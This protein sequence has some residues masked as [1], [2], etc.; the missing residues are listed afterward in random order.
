MSEH[1]KLTT[2]KIIS[3]LDLPEDLFLGLPNISLLGNHEVYISNHRGILSYGEKEMIIFIKDYQIQIKGQ[4]L[5][6]TFY[7]K[8]ELSIQ[9]HILSLEFI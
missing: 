4:G 5:N 6:I 3:T 1:N 2:K 7:S 8:D 9:G